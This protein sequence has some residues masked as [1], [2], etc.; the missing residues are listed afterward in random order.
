MNKL[1]TAPATEEIRRFISM[2]DIQYCLWLK[3]GVY[4]LF[5][6]WLQSGD[7]IVEMVF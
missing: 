7:D 2:R 5:K 4:E 6:I 3:R 1:A